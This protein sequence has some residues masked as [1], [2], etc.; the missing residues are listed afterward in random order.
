M[1]P[2]LSIFDRDAFLPNVRRI[3]VDTC[4]RMDPQRLAQTIADDVVR[5]APAVFCGRNS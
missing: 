4:F 1:K 2:T 5:G 3:G